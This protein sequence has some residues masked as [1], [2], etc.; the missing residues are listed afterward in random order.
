MD[1]ILVI[2][3]GNTSVH[4]AVAK[5]N[6]L[7]NRG[8]VPRTEL[9]AALPDLLATTSGPVSWCSV[10]P[11]AGEAL[12]KA[13][14]TAIRPAWQ[15]TC[16]DTPGLPISYPH[17]EQ[18]GQDRLANAIGAQL[19]VDAPAVVIDMGTATT[20]D[21]VT[22][23]QGYIGGIIA[24]GIATMTEYLHEKTA[25]LPRLDTTDLDLAPRIGRSTVEAMNVGCARGYPG[26]IRALLV[27]VREEYA[28]LGE[29]DPTVLL[30]GGAAR[31]FLREALSEYRAEPDLTLLGLAEAQRRRN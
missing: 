16:D 13:L 26:M 27:G 15:L 19:L 5:G 25:L 7:A 4:W 20:F 29:R 18:I 6:T 28:A 23:Q 24:P 2:D 22:E 14:S 21:L 11:A 1:E 12:A 10:V 17:P 9:L 3:I 8:D 30:T 31:G